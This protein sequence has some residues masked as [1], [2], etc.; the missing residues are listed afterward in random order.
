MSYGEDIISAYMNVDLSDESMSITRPAFEFPLNELTNP[1]AGTS[2]EAT[3]VSMNDQA[4]ASAD[5][6]FQAFKVLATN[7][8]RL[9]S[10]TY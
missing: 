7:R 3:E 1:P 2:V 8:T 10:L 4:A 6:E 9:R 5:T